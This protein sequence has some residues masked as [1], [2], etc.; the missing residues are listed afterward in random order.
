MLFGKK[1][2]TCTSSPTPSY[3]PVARQIGDEIVG[4]I[5]YFNKLCLEACQ[6]LIS[7]RQVMVCPQDKNNWVTSDIK[8]K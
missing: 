8:K 5:D 3:L 1:Q 2:N 4:T 7:F 6:Q